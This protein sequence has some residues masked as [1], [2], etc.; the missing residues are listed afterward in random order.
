MRGAGHL[1][2]QRSAQ[3]LAPVGREHTQLHLSKVLVLVQ[4]N[5]GDVGFRDNPCAITHH[6][7]RH[8]NEVREVTEVAGKLQGKHRRIVRLPFVEQDVIENREGLDDCVGGGTHIV[9]FEMQSRCRPA[10][11]VMR[12]PVVFQGSTNGSLGVGLKWWPGVTMRHN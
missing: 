2:E 4:T 7:G 5:Q 11:R 9:R 8:L 12:A 10:G 1:L 3:P 6:P